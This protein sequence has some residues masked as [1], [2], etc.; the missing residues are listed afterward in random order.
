MQVDRESAEKVCDEK[1]AKWLLDRKKHAAHSRRKR[2]R[3]SVKAPSWITKM[4]PRKSPL[5]NG[6]TPKRSSNSLR[7]GRSAG[8]IQE[9]HVFSPLAP[10]MTRRPTKPPKVKKKIKPKV[11]GV[12]LVCFACLSASIA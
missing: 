6:N 4:N 7:R 5:K 12:L 8:T 9:P 3:S 10:S 11:T 1:I 2:T